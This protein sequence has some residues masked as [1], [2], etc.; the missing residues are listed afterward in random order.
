MIT[1]LENGRDQNGLFLARGLFP[2]RTAIAE[3]ETP[4]YVIV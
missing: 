2:L 4:A 1:T 3:A